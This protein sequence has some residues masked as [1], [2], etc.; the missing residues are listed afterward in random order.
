MPHSF[1]FVVSS[2]I[3]LRMAPLLASHPAVFFVLRGQGIV[4]SG[5]DEV[6][7]GENQY[8]VLETDQMRGIHALEDLVILGVRS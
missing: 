4:T 1:S 6:E 2:L 7:L 5:D 8:I 3:S